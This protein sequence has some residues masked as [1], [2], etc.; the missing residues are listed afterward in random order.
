L[1]LSRP[2][3]AAL[4]GAQVLYPRVPEHRR[5]AATTGILGLMLACSAADAVEARGRR[6]AVLL[7]VA[8]GV[9]H[10][11]ELV[12]VRTGRPFGHYAYG[13]KLGPKAGG[14]PLAVGVPWALMA[15]PAWVVAGLVDR[16]PPRRIALA[17]CAL[18]AW[19]VFVDP[20]MVAD[21]YWRWPGGG[22]Y[23]GVPLSNFA[24]WLT[25][26]AL[27]YT[28][29]AALDPGDDPARDGDG[30]LA[31]YAW[32][33]VGE[34]FA[35]VAFWRRPHVALAGGL[36]MGAFAIPALARRLGRRR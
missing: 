17:A 9:A 32:T 22:R 18:T 30:A 5:T 33:W 25:C 36:A 21:G 15:R 2:L 34:I 24:G 1:R 28:A 19:D 26:G 13:D 27:V 12:G 35:N 16:R 4:V 10:A 23:A 8:A 14:V 7:A 31:L 20:R 6:G 29:W 11:V 3:F